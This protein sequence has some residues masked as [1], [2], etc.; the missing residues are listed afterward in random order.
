M[1]STILARRPRRL[2]TGVAVLF[3]ALAGIA[4]TAI[5]AR[6]SAADI[7]AQAPPDASD[8]VLLFVDD[9]H[10]LYRPGTH[11]V[12]HPAQRS[13]ANPLLLD[14]NPW[15]GTIA[16]CSVHRDPE[17]G[18]HQMWYQAYDS[19]AGSRLCYAVSDDGIHWTRP[20]LGLVE[21][22][23]S[24]DN[25]IV[26]ADPKYGASVVYDPDDPDPQRRY[27]AAYFRNGLAVAFSPDGVHWQAAPELAIPKYSGGRVGQPP[28][29][30]EA[31]PHYIPLTVSDVIDAS[32]DPARQC[33]M[34]YTKTWLDGPDGQTF[35]RRALVRTDSRDFVHWSRPTLVSWPDELD[36]QR[37]LRQGDP[38]AGD[39]AG[40]GGRGVHIHGGPTF[41]YGGVYFTLLQVVD[42]AHT[43]LMPIE[44]AVSRD[45]FRLQRPFRE[46]WFIPVDGRDSFDSGAIWSSA[47]PIVTNDE[48]RFYYGGYAGNWKRGL[49]Q[50]PTGIGLATI[51]LDRFAGLRPLV[52]RGQATLKPIDLT[53][54]ESIEVNAACDDGSVRLE[55]LDEQGFRL[56]G[57]TKDDARPMQGDSLR[58][59]AEWSEKRL[60]DLPDG[61]YTLR[62]H[63]EGD[64]TVYSVRIHESAGDR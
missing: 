30:D 9:H 38:A 13:P 29:A 37:T 23:G 16:Y 25:N 5:G 21:H 2:A 60:T 48:I 11:R 55:V 35:W 54:V 33:W 41:Y 49:I 28:F 39:T 52:E 62:L 12:L 34:L 36:E 22:A 19:S 53:G 63:L 1:R 45:G 15:E 7:P 6:C 43:G 42:S 31:P 46:D 32:Y 8:R 24:K 40:G 3:A 27:K 18:K 26:L 50:K 20:S 51:P 47:T 17:T 10:V 44:L 4:A 64:A 61:K 56:H 14:T 59:A 58:H 57:F